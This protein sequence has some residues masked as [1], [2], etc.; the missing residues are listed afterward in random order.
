MKRAITFIACIFSLLAN[1]QQKMNKFHI[2]DSLSGKAIPSTAVTIVRA[3][4][5]ITTEKD[6]IFIIPGNLALMRDTV[7]LNT[8]SYKQIRLPLHKLNGMDTIRLTKFVAE[9]RNE[10]LKYRDDTLL[11]DYAKRDI[12]HYAGISTQ[13]ASFD[14]LQWAQQFSVFKPGILLKQVTLN[15]L[16][17]GLDLSDRTWTGLVYLDPTKFR[18]RIYDID[19]VTNGPGR[20]LCNQVIEESKGNGR[21][22]LTI[23]LKKYNIILPNTTF[24]VA[25]EWLRDY[26]NAG[27]VGLYDAKLRKVVQQSNYRPAIGISPVKGNK[28]NIWAL[29]YK[30][31]WQPYTYF[32]PF[33][34]DLAIKASVEY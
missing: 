25:I 28:L 3:K 29:N 32:W 31:E 22:Q 17:F 20:D 8:Q 13:T 10:K 4:L 26:Y 16:A 6:G 19:P 18:I 5:S 14:Y 2:V 12:V 33:G 9:T 21:R 23:N 7:I 15:R 30:R 11:N 34:T 24:F 27:F 1:A